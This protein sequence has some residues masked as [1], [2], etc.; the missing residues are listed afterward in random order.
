[1]AVANGASALLVGSLPNLSA[2]SMATTQL[3]EKTSCGISVVAVG[4]VDQQAM[5]DEYV[6]RVIGRRLVE[7]GTQADDPQGLAIGSEDPASLFAEGTSGKHLTDLG[8]EED[9]AFCAQT[10]ILDVA[11]L[12][13][14]TGFIIFA[15]DPSN[16]G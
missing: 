13:D 15:W 5:E 4:R 8:Y 7:I 11:P 12:Y 6:A 16:P 14:G 1:M 2:V 3:A 9:V 10:D